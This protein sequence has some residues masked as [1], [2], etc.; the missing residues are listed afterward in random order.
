MVLQTEERGLFQAKALNKVDAE[1]DRAEEELEAEVDHEE[2]LAGAR[3]R[4]FQS[5]REEEE[6]FLQRRPKRQLFNHIQSLCRS[7][8]QSRSHAT[9]L[10][11]DSLQGGNRQP[12]KRMHARG[13]GKVREDPG[14]GR[15]RG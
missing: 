8:D 11:V 7:S 5:K 10:Q 4:G 14:Q 15:R 6:S 1:C 12:G 13:R 3:R 9:P 2:E